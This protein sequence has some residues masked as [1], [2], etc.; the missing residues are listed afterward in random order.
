MHALLSN[1]QIAT[2][3]PVLIIRPFSLPPVSLVC[4]VDLNE[5]T[6]YSF[7]RR[8]SF[9]VTSVG[10]QP[11]VL[12]AKVAIFGASDTAKYVDSTK[13]LWASGMILC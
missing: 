10:W 5:G 9:P 4:S 7:S 11:Q 6:K 1:T 2:R 12:L 8:I 13:R 3:V